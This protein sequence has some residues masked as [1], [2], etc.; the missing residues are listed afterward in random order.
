M[1]HQKLYRLVLAA[2]FAGRRYADLKC[3]ALSDA[4]ARMAD[5]CEKH[6]STL[7]AYFRKSLFIGCVADEASAM[8]TLP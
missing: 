1:N 7:E 4:R 5:L 6:L 3:D 2:L 8:Q